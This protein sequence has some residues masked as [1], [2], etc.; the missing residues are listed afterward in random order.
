MLHTHSRQQ[1]QRK[2]EAE[3]TLIDPVDENLRVDMRTVGL[4]QSGEVLVG[5]LPVNP[6]LFD[7]GLCRLGVKVP[8]TLAIAY[9]VFHLRASYRL[10]LD[11]RLINGFRFKAKTD[12]VGHLDV[13][14]GLRLSCPGVNP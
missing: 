8:G 1:L 2:G 5:H 4:Q 3:R 13:L 10:A 9:I 6:C 12:D 11:W 7:D 14:R